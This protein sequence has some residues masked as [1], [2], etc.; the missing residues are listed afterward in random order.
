VILDLHT[1]RLLGA[2]GVAL[3]NLACVLLIVLIFSGVMLW[4]NRARNGSNGSND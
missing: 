4:W 1:G 3:I 2:T